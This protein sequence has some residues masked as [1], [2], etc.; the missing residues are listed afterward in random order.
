MKFI[1]SVFVVFGLRR[2]A[3]SKLR[4]LIVSFT[5]LINLTS[6]SNSM[7]LLFVDVRTIESILFLLLR[8]KSLTIFQLVAILTPVS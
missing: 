2:F 4:L 7:L 8:Y 3:E 6:V 1:L 5:K